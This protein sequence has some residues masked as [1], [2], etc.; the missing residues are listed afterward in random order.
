MSEKIHREIHTEHL[1]GLEQ[2]LV[3]LEAVLEGQAVGS[4]KSHESKGLSVY[5]SALA[6][7]EAVYL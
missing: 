1:D 5:S 3:V 6:E 7:W 4:L 2:S